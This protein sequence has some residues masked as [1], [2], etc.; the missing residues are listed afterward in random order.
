MS[1]ELRTFLMRC[2]VLPEL[3]VARC[4][5]VSG[6]PRTASLF[7]E[8]E[9]RELFVT[10]RDA[11][12]LTLTLHDLFR[13][14]LN[15]RLRRELPDEVPNLL[16]AAADTEPDPIRRLS[17]LVS[18]G[19]WAEAESTLNDVASQLLAN[20]IVEA[21]PRLIAQF[22]AER[23][24]SSPMIALVRAW[25]AWWRWDWSQMVDDARLAVAGFF[26]TG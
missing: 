6:N 17:F 26:T 20:G 25:T 12:E 18:V 22:P 23:R 16:R 15:D 5:A 3:T 19:A 10:V 4:A 9:R 7:D 14:C 2:S 11:S 8:I 13:E 24:K 21:V 1:V